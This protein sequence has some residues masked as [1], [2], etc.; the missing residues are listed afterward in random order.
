[1]PN[2]Q[3]NSLNEDLKHF[4]ETLLGYIKDAED[5]LRDNYDKGYLDALRITLKTYKDIVGS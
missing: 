1:M 5:C 3:V 4:E 2:K